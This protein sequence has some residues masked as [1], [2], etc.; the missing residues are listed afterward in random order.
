MSYSPPLADIRF[1]FDEVCG[2]RDVLASRGQDED[3]E[4]AQAVVEEY[5]RLVTGALMPI[6]G[7]AESQPPAYRDG[8]VTVCEPYRTAFAQYVAAGWQSLQHPPAYG[9]QGVARLVAAA[10]MEMHNAAE[11]A[12]GNLTMLTDGAIEALLE[13]GSAQLRDRFLPHLVSGRW[14]GTMNLTEPQAGSDLSLIRSTATRH[15]DGTY[16]VCG[17]K[18][19]ITWGEHDLAENIVHLVLARVPGAP[20]GVKGLSLFAVPKFLVEPDGRRGARNDVFCASL[21]HKLGLKASPT[22]VM[23]FGAGHHALPE[24]DG[25]PAGALG[26]LVGEENRGLEYMFVMM[27]SARYQVGMQGLGLCERA[28]Q[29]ALA[30]ARERVQSRPVTGGSHA[31][32]IIQ[33]PDVRR[34]LMQQRALTEGCRAVAYEAAACADLAAAE[35]CPG[36]QRQAARR[37]YE[38]MVPLVKA[39]TTECAVE[40]SSLAIQVFGGMG[41][42]EDSGAPRLYRDARILPIYEGT[43]GIQANDLLGRKT[44]RDDGATA[45]EF[46]ESIRAT[47]RSLLAQDEADADADAQAVGRRLLSACDDFEAC[48]ARALALRDEDA[49]AQAYAGAVPYLQLVSLV[50]SGWMLARSLQRC[51]A[52]EAAGAGTAFHRQKRLTARFFADHLLVRTAALREEFAHGAA[53]VTAALPAFE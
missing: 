24:P 18:I 52:I 30:Y 41:F 34:M 42:I 31:V 32:P 44:L 45:Q 39:W 47:G 7:A 53:S 13:A 48:V 17:Q 50:F 26:Y 27:N 23:L 35:G 11:L 1:L 19:F 40:V 15:A 16:R 12:F 21:E 6:S 2:L 10:C 14:T 38:F 4:T 36:P 33:H 9:G 51:M 22:A 46:I 49:L 5:A 25:A 28:H 20:P 3:E 37:R 29:H 43:T 8:R